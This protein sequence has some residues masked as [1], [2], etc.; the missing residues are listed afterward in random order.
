MRLGNT[1][2]GRHV[3]FGGAALAA[4]I[5]TTSAAPAPRACGWKSFQIPVSSDA[6]HPAGVT[7]IA[8]VSSNDAWATGFWPN[9]LGGETELMLRWNGKHWSVVP[10]PVPH[11]GQVAAMRGNAWATGRSNQRALT[12][13]WQGKKWV[14]VPNPAGPLSSLT[15]VT[16]VSSKDVWAVGSGKYGALVLHWNG[17]TWSKVAG[18]DFGG[19]SGNYNAVTRIPGTAQVWLYGDYVNATSSGF[20]AARSTGSGWQTFTLPVTG[21]AGF[22]T[23]FR[24]IT[25]ASASSAWIAITAGN[26]RGQ[27]RPF[28]LHW[29]G[30]AWSQVPTPNPGDNS[31]LNSVAARDASDAWAVGTYLTSGLELHSFVLHWDG[32]NWSVVRAPSHTHQ[33]HRGLST[34]GATGVATVPG[35][36]LV[37]V[38]G[39]TLDE[40]RC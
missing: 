8:A 28:M 13:H 9:P 27:N 33:V 35:T 26:G 18:P 16:I 2:T 11:A 4:A 39:Q 14:V 15:D 17:S 20:A 19:T 7:T 6:T 22:S 29:D 25:A 31:Q 30:S 32:S 34:P 10:T 38:V 40:Y 5:V 37:W 21:A 12:M 1:A 23:T 24:T 36:K 3:A